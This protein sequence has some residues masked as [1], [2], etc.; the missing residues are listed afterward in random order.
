[1]AET[2]SKAFR[3]DEK[4]IE[5]INTWMESNGISNGEALE[6]MADIIDMSEA[7]GQLAGR[8]TEIENFE[9]LVHQLVTSYTASL[10][11]A[12]NAEA[13]IR[14]EFA[15]RMDSQDTTIADLQNR[16]KTMKDETAAA[17]AQAA[18]AAKSLNA[19][20]A[21]YD[22]QSAELEKQRAAAEKAA[23][24]A[25][26]ARE[27][28]DRLTALTGDQADELRKLRKDAVEADALRKQVEKLTDALEKEKDAAS[29]AAGRAEE[30]LA[31]ELEKAKTRQDA[32]VLAAEKAAQDELIRVREECQKAVSAAQEKAQA[33]GR[34]EEKLANELEKAK[35]RQDAA[36]LAAEKAAQDEL[37]K[38]RE[39]CQK[40]ISAAQEKAQAAVAQMYA[41]A[42]ADA[43]QKRASRARKADASES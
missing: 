5:R 24:D 20:Q 16:V 35:T 40:A 10:Q 2:K 30:K 19:L 43:K 17:K 38:V 12:Q 8:A 28:A 9:S 41:E 23:G 21:A 39:E 34:A 18:D 33:A 36:V 42:E 4:T 1:M 7:K 6:R 26:K 22:D 14:D 32:A 13:R 11:L 37:N 25:D 29:H 15:K 3:A 31:N 27:Q